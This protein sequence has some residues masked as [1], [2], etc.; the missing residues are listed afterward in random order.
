MPTYDY[1]CKSCGH[2]FEVFQSMSAEHIKECEKCGGP[3]NRLIG[4]GAGIIFKGSGFYVNDY[5]GSVNKAATKTDSGS[6]S[7]GGCNCANAD[8]CPASK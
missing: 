6:S 1:K 7:K 4:G 5:K 8:S 3:V 2:V